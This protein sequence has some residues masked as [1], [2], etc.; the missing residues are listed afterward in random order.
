MHYIDA[1]KLK[2]NFIDIDKLIEINEGSSINLIFRNKSE[3]Y[4]RKIESEITLQE[5]K[6][7]NSVIALGGG[8]FLN[9][10]IR[11]K[12]LN[13]KL[14]KT[15]SQWNGITY[16]SDIKKPTLSGYFYDYAVLVNITDTERT[17]TMFNI[18]RKEKH[19]KNI[20]ISTRE[21]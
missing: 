7:T 9:K 16:K 15:D 5:L 3:K 21:N 19:E 20:S 13:L 6:K 11:M 18:I 8:A 12:E 1:K 17:E 14:I 4:F 2:Y 10:L